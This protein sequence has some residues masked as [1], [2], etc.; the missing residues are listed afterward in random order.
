MRDIIVQLYLQLYQICKNNGQQPRYLSIIV[1]FMSNFHRSYRFYDIVIPCL[2]HKSY[3]GDIDV[4]EAIM[5]LLL[6]LSILG[7]ISFLNCPL[8]PPCCPV[9]HKKQACNDCMIVAT[10]INYLTRAHQNTYS[11]CSASQYGHCVCKAQ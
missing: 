4:K 7:L 10:E 5:H 3:K 1:G 9:V 11:M 8:Q 6:M 2:L